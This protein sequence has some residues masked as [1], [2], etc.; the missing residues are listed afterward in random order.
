MET[1]KK[2]EEEASR[3]LPVLPCF[4]NYLRPLFA[5]LLFPDDGTV[6]LISEREANALQSIAWKRSSSSSSS[7]SRAGPL[8]LFAQPCPP[9]I[10]SGW[11]AIPGNQTGQRLNPKGAGHSAARAPSASAALQWRLHVR[12]WLQ[13][14]V[15]V[16]AAPE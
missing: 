7:S 4:S 14:H 3:R 8:L 11:Q 9:G 15:M 2:E 13:P 16:A 1:E 12:R 6:C 10:L 5:F